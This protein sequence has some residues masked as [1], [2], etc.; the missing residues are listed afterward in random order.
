MAA[1]AFYG[2]RLREARE[3]RDFSIVQVA[4]H[5]GV[6]KQAVSLYEKAK[7][8]PSF[9]VFQKL[10]DLLRV[11]SHYFSVPVIHPHST[12]TF[13]RSM[14][15]A[16]KRMRSV[17]EQKL[18]WLR[19]ISSFCNSRIEFPELNIPQC[20]FPADPKKLSDETVDAAADDLRK[21][22]GMGNGVIS[23]VVRL[24]ESKGIIVARFALDTEKIDGFSIID[25][26]TCRPYVVL[27]ADK[28]T[29]FR[30]RMDAAHEL[31]HIILH[32]NVPPQVLND[33]ETF[34]AM[35]SQ[36]FRFAGSFLMPASTFGMEY[37]TSSLDSFKSIKLKWKSSIAAM[38]SR[39]YSLGMIS[40]TQQKTLWI[41]RSRRGWSKEEPYD[42]DYEAESPQ[43]LSQSLEMIASGPMS[44]E[45]IC[46]E[47]ALDK[48]DIEV[49]TGAKGFFNDNT[50]D[51]PDEP[52]PILKFHRAAS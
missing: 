48:S 51:E 50:I 26:D 5:L 36:A 39:A 19:Q 18:K 38:I 41:E 40:E 52:S 42:N 27:A 7:C 44:K 3:A 37:L 25:D 14:S 12:P 32:R 8:R 46:N 10:V 30:S 34:K 4:D 17:A 24:L 23:N 21:Y 43:L 28:E 35:E 13:Y 16:T 45:Q 33:S 47:I 6:T 29:L 49:I 11:P 2:E 22:W 1:T 15:S 9:D 31:G 20:M